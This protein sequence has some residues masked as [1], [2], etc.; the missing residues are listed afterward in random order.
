[1][2]KLLFA[3]LVTSS[4]AVAGMMKQHDEHMVFVSAD[5]AKKS[6]TLKGG[7]GKESSGPLLNDAAVK[8]VAMFKAGDKVVVTC[9]DNDKGE[10]VG[11]SRIAKDK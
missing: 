2:Y 4:L 10:H 7:D 5:T 1:M 6:V 11:V 8:A 9:D 3:G